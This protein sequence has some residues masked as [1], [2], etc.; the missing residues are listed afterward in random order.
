MSELDVRIS[1]GR[2]E[3]SALDLPSY[4]PFDTQPAVIE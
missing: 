3:R 1:A 2:N 4:Q